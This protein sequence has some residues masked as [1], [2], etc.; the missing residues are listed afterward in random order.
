MV[1]TTENTYK[2]HMQMK[3]EAPAPNTPPPQQQIQIQT[4]SGAGIAQ[5]VGAPPHPSAQSSQTISA[6]QQQHAPLS[7][8][9]RTNSQASYFAL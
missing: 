2:Y 9:S 6:A 8:P 4:G 3:S 1:E 7:P 5:R